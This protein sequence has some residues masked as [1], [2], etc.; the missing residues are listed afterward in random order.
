MT[1]EQHYRLAEKLLADE[2]KSHQICSADT[3]SL[4]TARLRCSIRKSNDRLRERILIHAALASAGIT[5]ADVDRMDAEDQAKLD[6]LRA[7][8]D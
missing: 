7:L 4:A 3:D 1:S 8:A 2:E 6:R 5:Q